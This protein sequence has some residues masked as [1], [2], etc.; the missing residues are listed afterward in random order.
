MILNYRTSVEKMFKLV[1][2]FLKDR[3]KL[4]VSEKK[5]KIVNLK[6]EYNNSWDLGLKL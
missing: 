4:E 5:S 2:I 6:K 1:K 3:L